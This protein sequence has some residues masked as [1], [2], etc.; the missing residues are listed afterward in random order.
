[1]AVA[2]VAGLAVGPV[3]HAVAYAVPL[4]EP[5]WP[6]R[7]P[8]PLTAVVSVGT[9]S[10]AALVTAHLGTSWQLLAQLWLVGLTVVLTLTD[11]RHRRLPN[12]V[13]LPGAVVLAV[14][15]VL[16]AVAGHRVATLWGALGGAA[17]LFVVFLLAA[18]ISP[19]GMGMGDVKL[20]GALGVVLGPAGLGTVLLAVLVAFAVHAVLAV[21]LL[22]TRRVS[23][24][25]GLPFGPALLL[26]AAVAL[27]WFAPV[28]RL[29]V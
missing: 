25:T 10:L 12:A 16:G 21:A 6:L 13:L 11:L 20:A 3:L 18:L 8:T 22:A 15:V 2:G 4:G 27:G 17:G 24:G 29:L 9:A 5:V 7:R 19:A 26:G 14:L 1:M 28:G 23:R